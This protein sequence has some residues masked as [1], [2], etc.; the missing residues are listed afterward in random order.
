M[1]FRTAIVA[2]AVA[3]LAVLLGPV[4]T[5]A[6]GQAAPD[7]PVHLRGVGHRRRQRDLGPEVDPVDRLRRRAPE[8]EPAGH[9]DQGRRRLA[10]DRDHEQVRT[11]HRR[12]GPLLPGAGRAPLPHRAAVEEGQAPRRVQGLD[13]DR[14]RHRLPR[15]RADHAAAVD[16]HR[17]AHHRRVPVP[18]AVALRRTPTSHSRSSPA[19]LGDRLGPVPQ[20]APRDRAPAS[21]GARG[22][23]DGLDR[24]WAGRTR[25][26]PVPTRPT[27]SRSRRRGSTARPWPRTAPPSVA[28]PASRAATR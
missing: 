21:D 26:E 8:G 9:P 25:S 23:R 15:A 7:V 12:A 11:P 5:G 1:R 28:M 3:L 18:D 24:A 4:R 2:V 17:D 10:D 14:L 22:R 13:L 20:R 19:Y 27:R 6:G 16:R